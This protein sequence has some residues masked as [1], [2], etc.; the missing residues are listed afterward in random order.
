MG[1]IG[2]RRAALPRRQYAAYSSFVEAGFFNAG[3]RGKRASC[4]V[5]RECGRLGIS[6]AASLG[7]SARRADG[8]GLAA[9]IFLELQ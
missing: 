4:G 1:R 8:N 9:L 7:S 3:H 5:A 2:T 6:P